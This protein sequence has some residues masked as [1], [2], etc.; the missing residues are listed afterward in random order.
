MKTM[1]FNK[2]AGISLGRYYLEQYI[3]QGKLGPIFL[4]NSESTTT[5]LV[6]F[7]EDPMYIAPSE[8]AIYLEQFQYRA[9]QIA[10][11][12]HPYLLP[13]QDYGIFLDVPYLVSPHLPLRSL[14]TRLAR[15]GAL[16]IFTI[17]RY[18]DQM[19][20]A[21]EYAHA[22]EVLHGNLTLDSIFIRLDGNLMLADV[23]V[24][25]LLELHAQ[26]MPS[27]QLLEWSGGYAP[28]QLLGK[29]SSP[30]TDVYALGVVIYYLLT[31]CD[32]FEANTLDEL[33]QQHL[34]AS[35]PP[36]TRFRSDLPPGLYG[37][38]ARAL[39]KDPAQRFHQPGAF[40]DAFHRT[41]DLTNRTR[42]PFIV[43]EA[44]AVQTL[45]HHPFSN[46]V[47]TIDSPSTAFALS[48]SKPAVLD[49][50][51]SS[52]PLTPLPSSIS[53]SLQ[54]FSID[55]SLRLTDSPRPA[56]MRRLGKKHQQHV[57]LF[58]TLLILLVLA[59]S[60]LAIAFLTQK[61]SA[62]SSASGQVTFFANQNDLAG[63]TNALHIAIQ[64]L[65]VPS[66]GNHYQA[67][68]VND[69]T[70]AILALGRLSGNGQIWSLTYNGG[71][72]NLLEVGDKLEITQEQSI[73]QA[74]TGNV[75]LESIFPV[76]AFAH[77]QHLLVSFPLT[78][79]KVGML[80]GLL[81]QTH[82]LDSQAAV[83]ESVA[84]SHNTV[85]VGC[86]TQ[87]MLDII[88][89][90]H[91]SH[92][93]PLAGVCSEQYGVVPG[94][95]FGL[96][97]KGFVAGAE[98]HASLALSQKDATRVMRQHAK[99]MDIALTNINGWVTTIDQ[100][101][102]NLQARPT[103]LSSIQAIVTLADN[104][105]YGVDVNGDG[106]IDPVAGEAGATTAY[107]QGQLMATLTLVPVA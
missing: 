77:I 16:D 40:A 21:L 27:N 93:H 24:K 90:T 57:V 42:L 28:E 53:H 56:L 106:Q 7:L 25:S 35:V 50:V 97:G 78:P 37:I 2:L 98:E 62:I 30:A 47:S 72:H 52:L 76:M 33:V 58:A 19:A 68:I 12:Q 45:A 94:D 41:V 17:G 44:P 59:G 31:N 88:E 60:T 84:G 104:A 70:E 67:W 75:I 20:T 83:L 80:I 51:S 43:S 5:Y 9:S 15:H 14:R 101:L 32:V 6:R 4:A 107:Q 11:L 73:V 96:L 74:P 23:G 64:H 69:S 34:Y 71:S 3:G 95:G 10:T 39:A 65:Q 92:Y 54:G 91:S 66:G 1:P 55:T 61:S 38:L 82:L 22:H 48:K 99:L 105:Y 46:G 103:D 86:V 49:E 63:Q 85:A 13:L 87:S 81:Q 102:L 89:G 26:V 79:G 8:R 36:L 29:P 18:L 100:D